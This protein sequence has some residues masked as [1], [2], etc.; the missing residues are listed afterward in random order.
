M[1]LVLVLMIMV[2]MGAMLSAF[3]INVNSELGNIGVNLSETRDLSRALDI[4]RRIMENLAADINAGRLVGNAALN[5]DEVDDLIARSGGTAANVQANV[6]PKN[7]APV[8]PKLLGAAAGTFEGMSALIYPYKIAVNVSTKD[9][10]VIRVEQELQIVYIPAFQFG[11]FSESDLA[12]FPGNYFDFGGRIH[13]NGDLYLLSANSTSELRITDR[14]SAAGIIIRTT[15]PNVNVQKT[16]DS[17]GTITSVY[18][19]TQVRSGGSDYGLVKITKNGGTGSTDLRTLGPNE[20]ND[21]DTSPNYRT[22]NALWYQNIYRTG[23]GSKYLSNGYSGTKQLHLPLVSNGAEP[24][25]IIRRPPQR[26]STSG[27]NIDH[28]DVYGQRFYAKASLRILLSDTKEDITRLPDIV[29]TPLPLDGRFGTDYY[30]AASSNNADFKNSSGSPVTGAP[31]IGGYILIE[32]QTTSGN[33]TN[34]TN[35]VLRKGITG[36]SMAGSCTTATDQSIIRLQR[37][38]DTTNKCTAATAATAQATDFWPKVLFDAREGF[39]I[40]PASAYPTYG[41]M[42][43]YVELDIG[44]LC[45]WLKTQTVIHKDGYAVYFSDRRTSARKDGKDTGEYAFENYDSSKVATGFL[46]KVNLNGNVDENKNDIQETTPPTPMYKVKTD[47]GVEY[48]STLT[49]GTAGPN[50]TVDATKAKSTRPL[51]FRRA[52]KLVN[53]KKIDLDTF[54]STINPSEY[55]PY[56]LT[57]AAENPV[58]IQGDYNYAN[59]AAVGDDNKNTAAENALKAS[60]I[61]PGGSVGASVIADAVTILSNNWKD[62]NSF[63]N[64]NSSGNRPPTSTFFRTAVITGKHKN[65]VTNSGDYGTDGGAHNFLRMLESWNE[66]NNV[67]YRGSIISLYYSQQAMSAFKGGTYAVPKRRFSYEADFQNF[68]KLPPMTPMFRDI[69]M[70]GFIRSTQS[71]AK[72]QDIPHGT[73]VP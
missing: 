33:W 36:P 50:A 62:Q 41:G 4:T 5:A 13:T 69:N 15:K 6:A 1:A 39:K 72:A 70:L 34:V 68:E 49:P 37:Y 38:N 63:T 11:M 51:Y 61:L 22:N 16:K 71:A 30:F 25:D 60:H 14:A 10:K 12:A 42:M 54:R 27:P 56:G 52:L 23:Y 44:N 47:G 40:D 21:G 20:G 8:V 26:S 59:T 35:E 67:F 45:T 55:I 58:Y 17:N 73:I 18:I 9:G 19:P 24:I 65:F 43:Y 2:L 57:V 29:G 7:T 31:L 46:S 64:V 53:G 28:P 3:I 66:N 32:K 48:T